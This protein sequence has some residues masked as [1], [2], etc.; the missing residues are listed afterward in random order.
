[1][2]VLTVAGRDGGREKA[3]GEQSSVQHAGRDGQKVQTGEG[4]MQRG[5]HG[6]DEE[7]GS[8]A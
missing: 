4:E 5:A 8:A 7:D 1:M 2:V 3:G 6:G